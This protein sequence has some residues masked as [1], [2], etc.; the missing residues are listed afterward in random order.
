[1]GLKFFRSVLRSFLY[2]GLIFVTLHL[3][4]K[5]GSLMQR[6]QILVIG[7]QSVFE[8]SLRNLPARLSIPVKYSKFFCRVRKF[9]NK[10]TCKIS[11]MVFQNVCDYPGRKCQLLL[12]HMLVE[13]TY[14][15]GKPNFF[16]I[17]QSSFDFPLFSD[18]FFI[19]FFS[20]FVFN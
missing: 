16:I 6:S 17:F 7:L 5:G 8:S 15:P 13:K 4:G 18:S 3:S 11:K 9:L 10:I 2:K 12:R 1:M 14:S 20:F 19:K